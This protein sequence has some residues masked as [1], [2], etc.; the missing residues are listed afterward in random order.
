[1]CDLWRRS[2]LSQGRM[3]QHRFVSPRSI[4]GSALLFIHY[5]NSYTLYIWV[6]IHTRVVCT[7]MHCVNVSRIRSA[8]KDL[9]NSS[10]V[11][12]ASALI[13]RSSWP[14][15]HQSLL[16]AAHVAPQSA[17]GGFMCA[18]HIL[19]MNSRTIWAQLP[20]SPS[21]QDRLIGKAALS[22]GPIFIQ[23]LSPMEHSLLRLPGEKKTRKPVVSP[24]RV[25]KW[26]SNTSTAEEN[27]ICT[28]GFFF[29]SIQQQ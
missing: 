18:P 5:N 17:R 6:D 10:E 11:L 28:T 12:Q 22:P 16:S 26:E 19:I 2:C 23:C 3:S 20:G 29:F 9:Y 7:Q 4:S 21:V 13:H 27:I 1:M 24:S 14:K 15:Q 8:V 25:T